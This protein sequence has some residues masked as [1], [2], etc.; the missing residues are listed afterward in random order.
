MSKRVRL[1]TSFTRLFFTIF[2]ELYTIYYRSKNSSFPNKTGMAYF[3]Y[4]VGKYTILHFYFFITFNISLFPS[5]FT[6]CKR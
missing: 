5:L 1:R 6:I 3:P 2:F 4:I